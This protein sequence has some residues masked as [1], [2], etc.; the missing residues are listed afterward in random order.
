MPKGMVGGKA[1][2]LKIDSL[3]LHKGLHDAEEFDVNGKIISPYIQI[4][5]KDLALREKQLACPHKFSMLSWQGG[6]LGS[7]KEGPQ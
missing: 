6:R 5:K 2:K 4:E 7:K 1:A 3:K